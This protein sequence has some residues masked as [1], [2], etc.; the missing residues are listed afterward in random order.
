MA[1]APFRLSLPNFGGTSF[2]FLPLFAPRFPLLTHDLTFGSCFVQVHRLDKLIRPFRVPLMRLALLR[3]VSVLRI[4]NSHT[5]LRP[6]PFGRPSTA[7]FSSSNLV[8]LGPNSTLHYYENRN[9]LPEEE[10]SPLRLMS[11]AR[12]PGTVQCKVHCSLCPCFYAL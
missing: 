4:L 2:C 7:G 6:S 3:N 11:P 5:T 9:V 8:G 12:G 1:V 10:G